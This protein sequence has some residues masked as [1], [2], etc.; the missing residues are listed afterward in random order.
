VAGFLPLPGLQI[1]LAVVLVNVL[2][3]GIKRI[4]FRV[5]NSGLVLMHCGVV[6]LIGGTGL[7]SRFVK[8]SVLTIGKNQIVQESVNLRQ[9]DLEVSISGI[10]DG[11]LWAFTKTFPLSSLKQGQS[12][13][14]EEV[15]KTV[16]VK[17]LYAGCQAQG[18]KAGVID[19]LV[20]FSAGSESG[21]I[22][23]LVLFYGNPPQAADNSDM[24]VYGGLGEPTQYLRRG[25]TLALS[26]LPKRVKLPLK[27]FLK[28]LI[29]EKHPGTSVA[30]KIQSRIRVMGEGISREVVVSMNRPFRYGAFTFYQTGFSENGDIPTSTF[31]V[32]ENPVRFLP[33]AASGLIIAGLLFHFCFRLIAVL[34]STRRKHNG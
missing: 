26:L 25:D 14:L 12:V 28:D 5:A 17:R 34:R 11:A 8:E 6:V 30:K 16:T 23:G 29:L 2:I 22:P 1:V 27:I 20:P 24:I 4:S 3:S 21:D 19:T 32:V 33:H 9:W 13:K 31:T 7:S 15:Q 18:R 10:D